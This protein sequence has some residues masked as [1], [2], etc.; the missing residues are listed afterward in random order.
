MW[1]LDVRGS[2]ALSVVLLIDWTCLDS[3]HLVANAHI[4]ISMYRVSA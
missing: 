3:V 4:Q 1:A 2:G